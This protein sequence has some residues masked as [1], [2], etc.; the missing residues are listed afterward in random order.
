MIKFNVKIILVRPEELVFNYIVNAE[1]PEQA[2]I[3]TLKRHKLN[4][5]TI[6]VGDCV[7]V[8]NPIAQFTGYYIIDPPIDGYDELIYKKVSEPELNFWRE[9][10]PNNPVRILGVEVAVKN[11]LPL[12]SLDEPKGACNGH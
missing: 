5:G 12:L 8:N 6:Q 9:F 10:M 2:I 11:V 7:I 3:L 4:N 1:S